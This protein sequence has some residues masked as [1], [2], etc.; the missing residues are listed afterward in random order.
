MVIHLGEV[1]GFRLSRREAWK[2]LLTISAQLAALMG[3][4][5][6]VNLVSSALKTASAGLSTALT[7]AAQGALAWYAT[8][9]T[10]RMAQAWFARGKSWG[11]AGPR[12]TARSI[13]ASLDRDSIIRDA[14]EDILARLRQRA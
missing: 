7:A 13:L 3:A 12:E 1:Y 8:Y 6:G 5:W 10:G 2:L 11:N 9:L 4:Y 14:R